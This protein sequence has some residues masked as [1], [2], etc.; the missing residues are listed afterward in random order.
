MA[1]GFL[2]G[3]P[4]ESAYAKLLRRPGCRTTRLL[5]EF[6]LRLHLAQLFYIFFA[7]LNGEG[8]HGLKGGTD[9]EKAHFFFSRPFI[10]CNFPSFHLPFSSVTHG[11]TLHVRPLTT[12]CNRPYLPSTF[13]TPATMS[14]YHPASFSHLARVHSTAS[15]SAHP[16]TLPTRSK[17]FILSPRILAHH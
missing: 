13:L 6:P 9:W 3:I 11:T 2:T 7:W 16:H 12:Y 1:A 17:L 10:F 4:L 5:A 8:T 15:H 14:C